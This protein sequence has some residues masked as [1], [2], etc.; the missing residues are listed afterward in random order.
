MPPLLSLLWRTKDTTI[1][2]LESRNEFSGFQDGTSR[3]GRTTTTAYR[4]RDGG[5]SKCHMLR[6]C[7]RPKTTIAA[8]FLCALFPSAFPILILIL[9]PIAFL[10]CACLGYSMLLFYYICHRYI[11]SLQL[12]HSLSPS[13]TYT[14]T[15][16]FIVAINS[17]TVSISAYSSISSS[18]SHSILFTAFVLRTHCLVPSCVHHHHRHRFRCVGQAQ[19]N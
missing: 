10:I 6:H 15:F 8:L 12:P 9:I 17:G 3:Q 19:P 7:G 16:Q 14:H 2:Q 5:A 13:H 4:Y 11:Y 18:S 1:N